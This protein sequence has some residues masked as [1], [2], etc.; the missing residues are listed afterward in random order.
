MARRSITFLQMNDIHG[1]LEP[2]PELFWERGG[3]VC[4]EAGGLARI[5]AYFRGVRREVDGKVI[6]LDKVT[7]FTAPSPLSTPAE[8]RWFRC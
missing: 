8:R 3:A 6:A 1:Y 2:H 7:P 4:R 5:A